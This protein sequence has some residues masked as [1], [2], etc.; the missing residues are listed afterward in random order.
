MKATI[1]AG[2][3]I[4]TQTIL[5]FPLYPNS[6]NVLIMPVKA[7]IL[8]LQVQENKP[9]MWVLADPKELEKEERFFEIAKT[10]KPFYFTG[11]N[12]FIGT[13]QLQSKIGNFEVHVFEHLPG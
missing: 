8:T 13:C 10:G 9:C 12:L 3:M 2:K 4:P 1:D 5:K 11:E 6:S 7:K